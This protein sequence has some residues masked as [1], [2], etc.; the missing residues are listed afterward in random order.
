MITNFDF[1]RKK[2]KGQILR[3]II[4]VFFSIL[5]FLIIISR[6]FL[7]AHSINQI[8]YGTLL[9]IGI[10]FLEIHIIYALLLG[11]LLVAYF[12]FDDNKIL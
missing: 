3:V 6:F 11:L 12:C 9:G 4:F 10:Y 7:S 5:I 2:R 1:F 8:I